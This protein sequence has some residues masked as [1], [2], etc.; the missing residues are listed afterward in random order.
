MTSVY[1]T[2]TDHCAF[3]AQLAR[4]QKVKSLIRMGIEKFLNGFPDT[5]AH[6]LSGRTYCSTTSAGHTLAHIRLKRGQRLELFPVEQVKIDSGA[7]V[8]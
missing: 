6:E 8:L 2:R 3:S 4:L 1:A 7:K 5:G